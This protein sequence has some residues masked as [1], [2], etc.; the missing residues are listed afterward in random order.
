MRGQCTCG[1]GSLELRH[2]KMQRITGCGHGLVEPLNFELIYFSNGK[3]CGCCSPQRLDVCVLRDCVE[4]WVER[5]PF[6]DFQHTHFD[7]VTSLSA[8]SL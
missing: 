4:L 6:D 8:L 2:E 7:N 5:S 1:P 3:C